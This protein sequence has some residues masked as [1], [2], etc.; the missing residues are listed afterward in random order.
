MAFFEASFSDVIKWAIDNSGLCPSST[1]DIESTN[2]YLAFSLM[3]PDMEAGD[4]VPEITLNSAGDIVLISDR[5]RA[6]L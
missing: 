1:T 2:F 6:R 4:R 5:V 3:V